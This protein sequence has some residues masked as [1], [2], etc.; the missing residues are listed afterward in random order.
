MADKVIYEK[1]VNEAVNAAK[2]VF[3]VIKVKRG[4]PLRL[5]TVSPT[6]MPST[7]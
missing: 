4:G 2:A 1:M 3:G 6:W 5:L 7:G